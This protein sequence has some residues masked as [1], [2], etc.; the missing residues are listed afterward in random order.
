M[1]HRE[2]VEHLIAHASDLKL[3]PGTIAPPI[4]RLFWQMG[5]EFPPP[6]FWS[7]GTI[8]F[9]VGGL[10]AVLWGLIMWLLQWRHGDSPF[11]LHF[12]VAGL[13]GLAFGVFM[14]LYFRRKAK[15]LGL[16]SWGTYPEH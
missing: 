12:I 13:T 2:K 15:Q 1:T 5:F 9:W 3:S 10:F 4:F 16:G 11:I 7:F 14:A 8:V 6:L